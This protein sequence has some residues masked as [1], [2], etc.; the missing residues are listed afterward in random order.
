MPSL[1]G[2]NQISHSTRHSAFGC[3]PGYD[4]SVP[5]ALYFVIPAPPLCNHNEFRNRLEEAGILHGGRKP[6]LKV[7]SPEGRIT[8][9][10]G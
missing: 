3:V 8:W 2:L 9:S 10:T 4:C 7:I 5:A 6:P 1:T